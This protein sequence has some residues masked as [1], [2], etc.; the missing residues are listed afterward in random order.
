LELATTALGGPQDFAHPAHPIVTPLDVILFF[1]ENNISETYQWKGLPVFVFVS[2]RTTAHRIIVAVLMS[3]FV[4][5]T[6]DFQD[7]FALMDESAIKLSRISLYVF[8]HRKF[9]IARRT[10]DGRDVFNSFG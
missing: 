5:C 4:L 6:F 10:N 2:L 9:D 3:F 8:I 7:I 1:P